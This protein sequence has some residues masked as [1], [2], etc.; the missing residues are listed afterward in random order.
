MMVHT[1]QHDR[2][3]S[4]RPMRAAAAALATA[5]VISM[6]VVAGN[7]LSAAAPALPAWA[8]NG[9]PAVVSMVPARLL[10][11]RDDGATIDGRYEGEGALP[12]G[13]EVALQ[14]IQRD[15][16]DTIAN[17]AQRPAGPDGASLTA[18]DST[19]VLLNV[20]AVYPDGPGFLTVYPCGAALPTASNVN[21]QAGD[22]VANSVLA[23]V[24]ADGEMCVYSYA[25]THLVV[26]V[27]GHV[28]STASGAG[29]VV[30]VVPARLLETR[31][32]PGITTADALFLG[33]GRLAGGG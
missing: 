18:D 25:T 21:Y 10:D 11:T 29:G 6:G 12:G 15:A 1:S 19:M 16:Y 24:G 17:P 22:A 27:V 23:P 33:R 13:Q 26:D 3:R 28:P 2:A 14:V 7:P 8:A 9:S 4:N 32:G 20:T 5:V 30:P 31:N